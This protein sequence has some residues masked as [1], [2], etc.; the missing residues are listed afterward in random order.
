MRSLTAPSYTYT[1]DP[2]GDPY[3]DPLTDF[4]GRQLAA[5]NRHSVTRRRTGKS[6]FPTIQSDGRLEAREGSARSLLSFSTSSLVLPFVHPFLL[7][8]ECAVCLRPCPFTARAVSWPNLSLAFTFPRLP[9][10]SA[11]GNHRMGRLESLQSG[12]P[13]RFCIKSAADT[14]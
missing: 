4:R 12:E 10:N 11:K 2:I 1:S 3:R 8:V 13:L 7:P 6:L 9:L 14:E 5:S